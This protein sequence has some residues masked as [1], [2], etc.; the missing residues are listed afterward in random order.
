MALVTV[1]VVML[2]SLVILYQAV[3]KRYSTVGGGYPMGAFL[4]DMCLCIMY[5]I[6]DGVFVATCIT[7]ASDRVSERCGWK[8]PETYVGV[9]VLCIQVCG[10]L[11]GS[12]ALC[13][14]RT[15]QIHPM[16]VAPGITQGE[17]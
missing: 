1:P 14:Y 11:Y 8:A 9:M 4:Q 17:D 13:N 16:A 3:Q 7:F 10:I 5:G 2:M 15:A 12:Y 6:W